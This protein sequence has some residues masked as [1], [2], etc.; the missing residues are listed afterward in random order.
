M[1]WLITQKN[2]LFEQFEVTLALVYNSLKPA[3]LAQ[4][5]V[6]VRG[7][8]QDKVFE[9]LLFCM[10]LKTSSYKVIFSSC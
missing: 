10:I 4:L 1:I 6:F 7:I 2:N 3:G 8:F 9:D 5:I